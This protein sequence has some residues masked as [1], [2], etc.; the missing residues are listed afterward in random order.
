MTTAERLRAEGRARGRTEGEARGRI[1]GEA[2]GR[3][4]G[5]AEMLLKL[6]TV[7][8]GPLTKEVAATV[9]GADIPQLE[10]W[11]TRVLTVENLEDV[12]PQ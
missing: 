4:E 1:E 9:R 7:K 2:R 11:A 5:E 6:L 8:F 10:L 12:F 3:V